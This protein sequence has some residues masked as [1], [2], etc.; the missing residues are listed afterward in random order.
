MIDKRILEERETTFSQML[1]PVYECRNYC[2]CQTL[3]EIISKWKGNR[4]GSMGRC[5]KKSTYMN[6]CYI[7]DAY[8]A[9]HLGTVLLH[10]IDADIIIEFIDILQQGKLADSTIKSVMTV[11]KIYLKEGIKAG[12]MNKDI[13][14]YCN[15]C[16][17]KPEVKVLSNTDSTQMKEYLL[18][19]NS[20][21]ALGV[22]LCRNTGIRIGEL[23]GLKWDDFNFTTGTFCIRRTV[24]RIANPVKDALPKTILYIRSPKSVTSQRE[25]PI[26]EY[27]IPELAKRK[28]T[29]DL[30]FLTD[31]P[32][33]TEP[34]NIQKRFKT[35][36]KHCQ[37]QNY[38]F[39][40]MR[41]GFATAC[42]D[43][44]TDFKTISSILGHA[45][46][47]TTMNIYGH[48]SLEKKQSC[49]NSIL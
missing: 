32:Y 26:P 11:L 30:Y 21:F 8:I 45:S 43:H 48:S 23:C 2:E 18:K 39:H 27:L 37:M 10:K 16:I 6:Y 49:I 40:A 29:D 3:N 5:I 12:L 4:V 20:S 38:N 25:I 19:Q 47:Q 1:S 35:V 13:L 41:H 44:G 17:H 9:P 42:L 7:T 22:L 15:I 14:E 28:K 31:S 46:I 33:C 34:R 36:L 24:S